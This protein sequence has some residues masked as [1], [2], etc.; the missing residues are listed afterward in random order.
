M[1]NWAYLD[2]VFYGMNQS[3]L[4]HITKPVKLFLTNKLQIIQMKK[5]SLTVLYKGF[6]VWQTDKRAIGSL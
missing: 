4:Q 1:A 5:T 6:H 3:C 2:F